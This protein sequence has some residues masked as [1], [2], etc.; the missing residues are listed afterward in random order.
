MTTGVK[1][2]SKREKR[3]PVLVAILDTI[4]NT[5]QNGHEIKLV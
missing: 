5:A 2:I 1:K 3:L 4:Q